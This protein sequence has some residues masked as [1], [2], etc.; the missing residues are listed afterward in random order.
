[1]RAGLP[2]A[3]GMGGEQADSGAGAPPV[4]PWGSGTGQTHG[5]HLPTP[6]VLLLIAI[7]PRLGLC[8]RQA[9]GC[10]TSDGGALS[11]SSPLPGACRSPL[12]GL[13]VSGLLNRLGARCLK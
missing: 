2:V 3:E 5:A 1:M 7:D 6:S 12:T 10:L 13:R 4:Q 11:L 9:H 8:S